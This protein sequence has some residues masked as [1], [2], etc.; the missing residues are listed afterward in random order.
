M[1]RPTKLLLLL[2]PGEVD[3]PAAPLLL[4]KCALLL[5]QDLL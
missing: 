4:L 5:Q 1:S 3:V 2:Q